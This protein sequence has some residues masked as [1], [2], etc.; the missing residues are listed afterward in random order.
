[1][2]KNKKIIVFRFNHKKRLNLP[3]AIRS[4]GTYTLYTPPDL[5]IQ[6]WF[7]TFFW[8]VKGSGE[9]EL[10][11]K[12]VRVKE[13]EIFY[14]LPG[15]TQVIRPVATPWVYHW[16][17]LDHDLAPALLEAFG[18][19]KRPFPANPCPVEYFRKIQDYLKEGTSHGERRASQVAH[20][21]LLAATEKI[22][23]RSGSRDSLSEQC[24]RLIDR[25]YADSQLNINKIAAELKV[26]RATLF[27]A[28][29]NTFD[30]TPSHYLQSKR[31]HRAIELLKMGEL[32]V[33]EVARE[34][35]MLDPNYMTRFIRKMTG[36]SS[37]SLRSHGRVLSRSFEN[38]TQ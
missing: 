2:P 35:G 18:F 24:K 10:K 16:L 17:N 13:N 22:Y 26:H 6:K 37:S 11:G 4:S 15:E 29:L 34:V 20:N 25:Q 21:I 3:L 33:Q 9:F 12:K 5:P 7:C 14:Y 30:M 1:M 23:N 19:T 31:F 36:M 8:T 32:N 28:F 27:R 38:S